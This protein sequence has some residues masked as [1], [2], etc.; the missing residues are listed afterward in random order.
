[1]ATLDTARLDLTWYRPPKAEIPQANVLTEAQGSVTLAPGRYRIR[2]ISDDGV[3]VFLDDRVLIHDWAP[4]ESRVH[5]AE[6]TAAGRHEIRVV[7][8]QADG[9]YELRLDIE[10]VR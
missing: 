5:E 2:S 8:F 3:A 4:G 9:W 10:R 7:H 1:M 6:F